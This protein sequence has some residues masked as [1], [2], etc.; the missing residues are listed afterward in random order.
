MYF[1]HEINGFKDR[2]DKNYVDENLSEHGMLLCTKRVHS[3]EIPIVLL[4]ALL[5]DVFSAKP[6]VGFFVDG[7][8]F[9]WPLL[10]GLPLFI[11]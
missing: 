6:T 1:E 3:L 9:C 11:C 7:Y 2:G 4:L 10:Y 8:K 5:S